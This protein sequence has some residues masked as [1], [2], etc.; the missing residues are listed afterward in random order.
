[1]SENEIVIYVE[2]DSKDAPSQTLLQE[3]RVPHREGLTLLDSLVW[4][5]E[6]VDPTLAVLYSC[7]WDH[8]CKLC[9]AEINGE[10]SYLCTTLA[11]DGATI[12]GLPNRNRIRDIVPAYP[13]VW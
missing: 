9:Q 1:M 12:K 3:Y 6:N 4:I 7:R 5:R 11:R 13:K 2:R 10:T 8:T